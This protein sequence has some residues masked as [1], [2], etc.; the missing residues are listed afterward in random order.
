ML[1]LYSWSGAPEFD[2]TTW[3]QYISPYFSGSFHACGIPAIS[4]PYTPFTAVINMRDGTVIAMDTQS[5][6]DILDAVASADD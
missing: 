1:A 6:Q 5:T 2:E 3:S 4:I